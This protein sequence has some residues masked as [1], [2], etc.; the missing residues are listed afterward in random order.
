MA[1]NKV[2]LI[3]NLGRDPEVRTLQ[4]GQVVGNFSLA[5]NESFTDRAG[6]KREHTEWHHI[7]MF[8][9]L[10]E[11]C[12]KHLTKGRQVYVEG[13]LRNREY[14]SKDGS[15]KRHRTEIVALR[16]EFLGAAPDGVTGGEGS[17]EETPW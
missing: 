15:G 11:T 10:A 7:V 17:D 9:W 2:M 8:G 1:L 5:T 4:N 14:E 6:N 13:P 16:V 3:G 12:G